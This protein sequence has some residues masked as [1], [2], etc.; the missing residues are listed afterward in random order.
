MEGLFL[1]LGEFIGGLMV[2]V[3]AALIE[4]LVLLGMAML[5]LLAALLG[6]AGKAPGFVRWVRARKESRRAA[7]AGSAT[8]PPATRRS[9]PRRILVSMLG[10]SMVTVG[11]VVLLN[12]FFLEGTLRFLL[13]RAEARTGIQAGFTSAQGSLLSGKLELGD[14]TLQRSGHASAN[15]DLRVK[16]LELAVD[17][18]TVWRGTR[19][20]EKLHA[21]GVEGKAEILRGGEAK[22][23]RKPFVVR[24]LSLTNAGIDLAVIAPHGRVDAPVRVVRWTGDEIDSRR[25][26]S[27]ILFRSQAE[28]SIAGGVFRISSSPE[29]GGRVTRWTAENL[30]V[31]L[32]A[33]AAGGTLGWLS[34]GTVN[35]DVRD[36]WTLGERPEVEMH[37]SL[38]LRGVRA[39]VPAGLGPVKRVVAE[40]VV[41]HLNGLSR[42]IPLEFSFVLDAQRLD[43]TL[44][45]DL[46]NLWRAVSNA[47]AGVLAEKAGV[48]VDKVKDAARAGADK[49]KDFLDHKR[50][51]GDKDEQAQPDKPGLME[52]LRKPKDAPPA[53]A[54]PPPA[55]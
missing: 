49:I 8:N 27:T 31:G 40:P 11:S 38:L 33:S 7:P 6:L 50:K 37:W 24:N 43:G 32:L 35:L 41:A 2:P 10:L 42:D 55:G 29:D 26:V 36:R 9:W 22:P 17:Y 18:L 47:A 48:A 54:E 5:E 52:R 4:G 45:V 1:L 25:A 44:S 46:D 51:G 23:R 53:S 12:A 16:R 28:G 15:F 3:F 19:A 39:E 14:L 34:A 21:D 13:A 30:P 20:V